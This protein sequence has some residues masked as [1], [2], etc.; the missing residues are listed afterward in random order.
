[1]QC[2]K[3]SKFKKVHALGQQRTNF[4]L[5]NKFCNFNL[6]VLALHGKNSTKISHI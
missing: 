6:L 2:L 4:I 5:E 3:N 1:M